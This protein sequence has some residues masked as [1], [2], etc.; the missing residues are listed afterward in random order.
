MT[1]KTE[2]HYVMN[3]AQISF[4][5]ACVAFSLACALLFYFNI[6]LSL[7][8]DDLKFAWIMI[9]FATALYIHFTTKKGVEFE[10]LLL[11][12]FFGFIAFLTF[13]FLEIRIRYRKRK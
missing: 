1:S 5:S 8:H 9:G 10:T 7:Y 13:L 4:F 12:L 3:A 2:K 11:C 6:D